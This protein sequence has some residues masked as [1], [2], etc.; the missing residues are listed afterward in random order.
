LIEDL[1]GQW[2]VEIVGHPDLTAHP[3]EDPGRLVLA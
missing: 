1:I 3:P 2:R